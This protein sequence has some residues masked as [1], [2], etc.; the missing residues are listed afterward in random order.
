M[1]IAG[2]VL[3][4]GLSKRMGTP[5]ALISYE[6]DLLYHKTAKTL[7]SH[8]DQ[9]YISGTENQKK[10]WEI[11]SFPFLD[12]LYHDMGPVAGI[13]SSFEQLS[14]HECAILTVA[15]DMPFMD[16]ETFSTLISHRNKN[17]MAT[18][19]RNKQ[20]GFLE[21]LCAIYEFRAYARIRESVNQKQYALHKIFRNEELELIDYNIKK[22]LTNI[23]YPDQLDELKRNP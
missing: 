5:K 17:K 18:I 15:T 19:F 20:S 1:D 11:L 9:V 8:V 22:S 21:P 14:M 2:I 6:G 7:D 13:L 23:N 12:D 4:G 16:S 3:I 10:H